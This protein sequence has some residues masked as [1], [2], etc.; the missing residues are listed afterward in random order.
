MGTI[1]EGEVTEINIWL[2][3]HL[4]ISIAAP[5][6]WFKWI[7]TFCYCSRDGEQIYPII[8]INLLLPY[9]MAWFK[10]FVRTSSVPQNYPVQIA[11]SYWYRI[12][13]LNPC[14]SLQLLESM[15]QA[16]QPAALCHYSLICPQR[17]R[18]T[19]GNK[20]PGQT[21]PPHS[22]TFD[23]FSAQTIDFCM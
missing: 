1:Q 17:L 7:L 9:H 4:R 10:H 21:V 16:K 2:W 6:F 14:T 20:P 13:S 8:F 3:K 23:F 22:V 11:V 12:H 5:Q 19:A 18:G 15:Q